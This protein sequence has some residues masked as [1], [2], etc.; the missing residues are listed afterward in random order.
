MG[1]VL[2]LNAEDISDECTRWFDVQCKTEDM[3]NNLN[4][5]GIKVNAVVTDCTSQYEAARHWIIY[6]YKNWFNKSLNSILSELQYY[7]SQE[8]LF[9]QE[10]FNQFGSDVLKYW[11]FCKGIAPELHLVA[12]YK[13]NIAIPVEENDEQTSLDEDTEEEQLI[14]L[15][16]NDMDLENPGKQIQMNVKEKVEDDLNESES[17]SKLYFNEVEFHPVDDFTAK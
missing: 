12:I 9:N 2:I 6:Y 14:S 4:K 3:L 13:Q 10:T 7:E 16:E 15:S 11:N 1:K 5:E 8:Y 17:L